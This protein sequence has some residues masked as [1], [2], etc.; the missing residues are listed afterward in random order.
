[1]RDRLALLA[2][3]K[4]TG[5]GLR[6]TDDAAADDD[7]DDASEPPP[8]NAERVLFQMPNRHSVFSTI[9]SNFARTGLQMSCSS[10]T[11]KLPRAKEGKSS[12]GQLSF[13][14]LLFT[15]NRCC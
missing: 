2:K 11:S 13:A 3:F 6:D 8:M 14:Y 4:G 1:M 9:S 12:P 10:S 15:C 5:D 7:E